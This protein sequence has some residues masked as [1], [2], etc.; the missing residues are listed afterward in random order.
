MTIQLDDALHGLA[1]S[2]ASVDPRGPYLLVDLYPGDE[3]PHPPWDVLVNSPLF[4]GAIIKASQGVSGWY[5]DR[6]WFKTN[7]PALREAG[8]A[9]SGTTWLRGAYHFLNFP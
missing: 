4:V 2:S 9:R 3:G 1:E 7:W 6:G 8:G 5:N